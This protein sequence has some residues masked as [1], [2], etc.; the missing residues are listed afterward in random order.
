MEPRALSG[1]NSIHTWT[2]LLLRERR[3]L[4]VGRIKQMH[5]RFCQRAFLYAQIAH[6]P[7]S[8]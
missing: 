2:T 4:P 6:T 5:I 3:I 7:P 1:N 8:A